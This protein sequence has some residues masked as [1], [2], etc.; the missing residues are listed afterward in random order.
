MLTSTSYNSTYTV[1]EVT[2]PILNSREKTGIGFGSLLVAPYCLGFELIKEGF[3]PIEISAPLS[4]RIFNV[5]KGILLLIPVINYLFFMIF[6]NQVKEEWKKSL[7]KYS[8]IKEDLKE[9]L[10]QVNTS[11]PYAGVPDLFV[12]ELKDRDLSSSMIYSRKVSEDFPPMSQSVIIY[13]TLPLKMKVLTYCLSEKDPDEK[14]LEGIANMLSKKALDILILQTRN[15]KT[16]ESLTSH[17]SNYYY[18]SELASSD[19]IPGL[20]TLFSR[21]T[22]D[23]SITTRCLQNEKSCIVIAK[24]KHKT[25]RVSFNVHNVFINKNLN[26]K[27]PYFLQDPGLID[28]SFEDPSDISIGGGVFQC[29][30]DDIN[31]LNYHFD[32]GTGISNPKAKIRDVH[33]FGSK[34]VKFLNPH[35]SYFVN[36]PSDQNPVLSAVEI[37]IN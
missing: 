23:N 1:S 17:L 8:E 35:V 29:G 33:L 6:A 31:P 13:R 28:H 32:K 25:S 11:K 27:L 2:E 24:A 26:N 14:N 4:R 37:A 10:N 9:A 5:V 16:L 12:K 3:A 30:V 20:V 19:S 7:E 36:N 15:R 22:F 21:A 34:H 18:E